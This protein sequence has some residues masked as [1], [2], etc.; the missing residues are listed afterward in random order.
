VDLKYKGSQPSTSDCGP[1]SSQLPTKTATITPTHSSEIGVIS[2]TPG[3]KF[4]SATQQ[5]ANT[6]NMDNSDLN[7]SISQIACASENVWEAMDNVSNSWNAF[8]NEWLDSSQRTELGNPCSPIDFSEY[9]WGTS[10]L[11]HDRTSRALQETSDTLIGFSPSLARPGIEV[12]YRYRIDEH[13][14]SIYLDADKSQ[15]PRVTVPADLEPDT[16]SIWATLT[17]GVKDSSNAS[18]FKIDKK[19]EFDS[20]LA[21]E[22]FFSAEEWFV[23]NPA[24]DMA[25]GNEA[26]AQVQSEMVR[27]HCVSGGPGAAAIC[28]TAMGASAMGI[29]AI[30]IPAVAVAAISVAAIGIPVF[31][32]AAIGVSRYRKGKQE[33]EAERDHR[34][35]REREE[36]DGRTNTSKLTIKSDLHEISE[37]RTVD[38]DG[39]AFQFG[40]LTHD[41]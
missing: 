20:H 9:D 11:A 4:T 23:W 14:E 34:F 17:R 30:G 2:N 24:L 7:A 27:L 25:L 16:T 22:E 35:E 29:A 39:L 37:S 19:L 33:E 12:G 36:P 26:E 40:R 6:S 8:H 38:V 21:I 5:V 31:A 18:P 15:D 32:V 3:P 28:V 13:S 41:N 1:S 10:S